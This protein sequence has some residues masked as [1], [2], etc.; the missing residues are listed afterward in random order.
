MHERNNL[1]LCLC[2]G[3]ETLIS[4]IFSDSSEEVK[5]KACYIFASANQNNK[6]VQKICEKLGA[7]QIVT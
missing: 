7:M 2:G 3:M 6:P 1:N 5:R 4:I